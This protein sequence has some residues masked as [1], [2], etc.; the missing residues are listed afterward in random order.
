MDKKWF[1]TWSIIYQ[2][3]NLTNAYLFW[4]VSKNYFQQTKDT[5]K[6]IS[7]YIYE[8]DSSKS[9]SNVELSWF[10]FFK[11]EMHYKK[12][13]CLKQNKDRY[14]DS[15][16]CLDFFLKITLYARLFSSRVCFSPF[17]F[18][19]DFVPY[20]NSDIFPVMYLVPSLKTERA[21]RC[22]N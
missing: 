20:S 22:K 18:K 12:T 1:I 16:S 11:F 8:A 7:R 17:S 10:F 13:Q 9:W 19:N 21:K 4:Y 15:S 5:L 14:N 2:L 3:C 6:S